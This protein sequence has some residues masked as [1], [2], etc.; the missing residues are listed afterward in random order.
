V[1][2]FIKDFAP[3]QVHF[4]GDLYDMKPVARWSRE[5]K[6]EC[7]KQLQIEADVGDAFLAEFRETYDGLTT[8]TLGNHEVRLRN[9]L[10]KYAQGLDGLRVLELN[11]FCH[12]D[13]YDIQVKGQ[14]YAIAPGV[15]AI[16][17]DKLGITAGASALKEL[18]R[19]GR[20]VVQ[21]H[22]HRLGVVYHTTD[23]RRFA[24]EFGWLG[25]IRKASYLSFGVADWQLG[26]GLLTVTPHEA[27]PELIP[28]QPNGSFT[29]RGVR[30]A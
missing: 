13:K 17:G 2:R 27:I 25:D 9:Y 19:H 29:V 6:A 11:E 18:R 4:V 24:A 14:P 5:T 26:F 8:I 20:S 12:F 21:G 30:Y 1:L 16:H 7:G 10:M 22:S 28:V 3:D 15:A 23:K